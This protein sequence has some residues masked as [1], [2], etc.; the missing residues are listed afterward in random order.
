MGFALVSTYL[1]GLEYGACRFF[2]WPSFFKNI[3]KIHRANKMSDEHL[4]EIRN[5]LAEFAEMSLVNFREAFLPL[6]RDKNPT[7][8]RFL[9]EELKNFRGNRSMRSVIAAA[10]AERE[11]EIYMDDFASVIEKETDLSLCRECINGLVRLGTQESVQKLEF[12]AKSKPNANIS[13]LLRQ[14]LEKMRQDEKEPVNYYTDQLL[15]GSQNARNCIRA[16]KV[17]IKIGDSKVVDEVLSKFRGLD[18]LGRAESAKVLARLGEARHLEA[19]LGI[20]DTYMGTYLSNM[21]FLETVESFNQ[22][23]REDR[24]G[25]LTEQLPKFA[26]KEQQPLVGQY[27]STVTVPNLPAAELLRDQI[28]EMDKPVGLEYMLESLLLIM[29]N[30]IAHANKH[31]EEALRSGRVRHSRLRHL[32]AEIGYGIGKIGAQRPEDDALRAKCTERL[33]ELVGS[34]DNDVSKMALFGT[35]YFV[36]P[37]DQLLLDA[38]LVARQVEGMTRLLQT[39]ERK[40]E[41]LFSDFFLDV[42]KNH[43]IIDIQEMAMQ[44]LNDTLEVH[45][46]VRTMLDSDSPEIKRTALRIIGEIKGISFREDLMEMLDGQSDIIRIE[47]IN[48]LGKLGDDSVLA[49]VNEVMYDAKSLVLTE[50]CLRAMAEVRSDEGINLLQDFA[51]KTRNK[52]MAIIAIQLLVES[53]KSWSRSLPASA[54]TIV[55]SHLKTWFED[56]DAGVRRDAFKIASLVVSTDA[57]IYDTFKLMF[58]EA[59]SRLRAQANWDKVEMGLVNECLRVVNR[60]FFFLKETLEF[61]TDVSNRCRN[62]EH[63]SSTTRIGVFEKVVQVLESNEKFLLSAANETVLEDV[64]VKGLELESGS[65]QEQNLLFKIAA[66]TDSKKLREELPIRLKTVPMQAKSDLMDALTR[67][68]LGLVEINEL[69]TIKKILVLEGSGF[70]RKRMVRHL[71]DQDFEVRDTNDLEIALV[72]IQNEIPDLIISEI[73]FGEPYEGAEFAEKVLKQFGTRIQ[74]IFST[75]IRDASILERVTRIKPIAIYHK[76]YP[77]EKLDKAIKG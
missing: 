19:V 25:L 30:K 62:Y 36:R 24:I 58:K 57:K 20:L 27:T 5:L 31:H 44:A 59:S 4:K 50:T 8:D 71:K 28:L 7:I 6:A 52:K 61:Q 1:S 10:M 37:S 76:P 73:T 18:D 34:A 49:R 17:L 54:Q 29:D 47:A 42:A 66:F 9:V 2:N 39:L 26:T 12:L 40:P 23:P 41:G 46:K 16:A 56:R 21:S 64:V 74:F 45:D 70:Y 38:A 72:M 60:N 67:L 48:S 53:Y 77:L 3:R 14:E 22:S 32:V 11:D 69:T 33:I 68:G 43:E 13:S 75:N 51:G 15:K 63:P 65:W 55:L 35:A